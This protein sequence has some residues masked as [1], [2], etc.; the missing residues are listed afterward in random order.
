[1]KRLKK[2][3]LEHA[4]KLIQRYKP[5]TASEKRGYLM[6]KFP[7]EVRAGGKPVKTIRR[8]IQVQK[9]PAPWIKET[10]TEYGMPFLIYYKRKYYV[11]NSDAGNLT[12]AAERND[13]YL[14]S[15]Y[16]EI[17]EV[18]ETSPT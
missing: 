3:T 18:K 4:I 15:L 12:N 13:S 9:S 7:V 5:K 14:Q 1:M 16:I 6:R 11:L 17:G 10:R 8:A 2:L